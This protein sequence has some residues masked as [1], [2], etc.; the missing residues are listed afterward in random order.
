MMNWI[1]NW[2]DPEGKLKVSAL[3]SNLLKLFLN[4]FLANEMRHTVPMPA[5]S[6]SVWSHG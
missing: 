4:G 1:Y 3:A 2:Y 5:E 6:P